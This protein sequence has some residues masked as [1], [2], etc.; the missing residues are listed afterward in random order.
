MVASRRPA[1]FPGHVGKHAG[2]KGVMTMSFNRTRRL[3]RSNQERM[4]AGVAGGVAQYFDVD[5]TIVRVLW[6]MTIL[7]PPLAFAALLL[8][9][10]LALIIPPA[11]ITE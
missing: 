6:V 2:D 11:P 8:Y 4:V 1:C 3:Y 7:F 10:V 5:P 9:I